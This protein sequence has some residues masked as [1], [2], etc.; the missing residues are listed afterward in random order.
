H[1]TGC[2]VTAEEHSVIG[3]LGGAVAE[4]LSE[5]DPVPVLR[6]GVEDKFGASGPATEMLK[7]YGLC[8]ENIVA[9]AKA[10]MGMKK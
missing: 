2:V 9:K 5:S 6:V 1:T 3:G 7:V 10:A 4:A 8:A